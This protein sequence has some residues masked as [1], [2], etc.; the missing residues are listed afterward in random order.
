M[1]HVD[2]WQQSVNEDLAD[3]DE[4]FKAKHPPPPDDLWERAGEALSLYTTF[5]AFPKERYR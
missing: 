5:Q 3:W 4:R 1:S 2:T